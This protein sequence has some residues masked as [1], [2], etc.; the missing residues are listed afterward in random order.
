MVHGIGEIRIQ[1]KPHT[2]K[3][4]A[5]FSPTLIFQGGSLSN[6]LIVHAC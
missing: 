1:V 4:H 6:E 3:R 2:H 5:R